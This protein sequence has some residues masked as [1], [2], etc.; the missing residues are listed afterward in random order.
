MTAG[1]IPAAQAP[2]SVEGRPWRGGWRDGTSYGALGLPLA[3]VE[4]PLYVLLPNFY[5]SRYGVPLALLG[6]V[7]LSARL[8]DAIADPFIGRWA[9]ALYGRSPRQ[10]YR[11]LAYAAVG[12]AIGFRALFFPPMSD[13]TALMVWCAIGLVVTY[14]SFSTAMVIHQAWGARLAGDELQRARIVAWREGFALAGVMI[15]GGL[16]STTSLDIGTW[17]FA[18]LL[19]AGV[20]LLAKAPRAGR[21]WVERRDV[22]MWLPWQS[23][24]FRRLLA[25]YLFNG[26][27]SAVPATLVLFFIQDRLEAESHQALFLGSYFAAAAVAIPLWV[28]AV[29][30]FGLAPV[31]LAAMGLAIATFGWATQLGRGD[32]V[33]FMVVCLSSGI[34]LGADLTLPSAMLTGVIQRAGHGQQAEGSYFGWWSFATKLNLALAAGLALPA[35]QALGYAAGVR[36]AGALAALTGAYCLLPCALKLI[37]AGLLYFGWI[38]AGE[39]KS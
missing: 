4:L 37:A 29:E 25:I 18:G 34:A 11:W 22:S 3:F 30:R 27:A 5:A 36:E 7:L 24:S 1:S 20:V 13:G 2:A 39:G 35:L 6:A 26:I 10:A 38:R 14:L 33:P 21:P 19:A 8:L 23:R 16:R 17:I 32:V 9:D 15:A 12:L 31:W 28:R